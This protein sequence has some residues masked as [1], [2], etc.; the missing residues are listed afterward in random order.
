M[1]GRDIKGIKS[2]RIKIYPM[3]SP[4]EGIYFPGGDKSISHRGI[5]LSSLTTGKTILENYS[6][7]LDVSSTISVFEKL[8]VK[9]K[10]EGNLLL[11]ES[12]GIS[13]FTLKR[14]SLFCGNSGTTARLLMGALSPSHVKDIFITGDD[15]LSKRPMERVIKPLKMMGA[16]IEGSEGT[17]PVKLTGSKIN[18]IQ[19]EMEVPSAQVKSAILLASLFASSK[20]VI[21]EKFLTREHTE[22]LLLNM[23]V[24]IKKKNLEIE[25]FP[26]KENLMSFKYLKIPGDISSASYF[27]ALSLLKKGS[28]LTV[29]NI[30]LDRGR[31]G[32]LKVL[33]RMGAKILIEVVEAFPCPVGDVSVWYSNLKGTKVFS[34]EIPQMIDEIP[35]L[36]LLMAKSEGRSVIMGLSEL[37][38]KESDRLRAIY[39]ILRK[40]GVKVKINRDSLEIVGPSDF[41]G[42][43]LK[44]F[45]HRI[46]MMGGIVGAISKNGGIIE[47]ANFVDISYPNF[48]K[49]LASFKVVKLEV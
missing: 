10:R 43:Y 42:I 36:S 26:V 12:N 32:F 44:S 27:I 16:S 46:L 4:V 34:H 49:D 38:Y 11:I 22:N 39:E 15:S 1:G 13:S 29:K 3:D 6:K 9:F 40:L 24:N 48:F 23:G 2:K 5:F 31:I 28:H 30:T 18:G 21:R 14:D 25:I 20:S 35:I 37:K 33:K 41:E 7:C 8:G 19:Y 47:D 45:D 17:L